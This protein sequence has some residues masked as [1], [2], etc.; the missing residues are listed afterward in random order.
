ML[1]SLQAIEAYREGRLQPS[2]GPA[3]LNLI[4]SAEMPI[5]N[6]ERVESLQELDQRN[7]VLDYVERSL[8]LLDSL[9]LSYWIK[10]LAEETLIWSETAKGGT[11]RQRRRWQEEGLNCFAHNIGSAQLYWQHTAEETFEVAGRPQASALRAAGVPDAETLVIVHRLIETHG[12][13][14]QQIRGE[15]PPEVNRPLAVIME[16]GLLTADELERLLFA[17]NHCIIGAVSPVLWQDVRSEIMELIAAVTSG[18]PAEPLPMK[19]RLRRMRSGPIL[20]GEDFAAEWSRLEQEGLPAE[21]LEELQPATFWYAES[22]LQTFSLEQFL[23]VLALAARSSS[24]GNSS[25]GNG[26]G[27]GHLSFEAVMNSIYYDYKGTK[28]I[29]VYKKRIIEKYLSGL[30]WRDIAEGKLA[31]GNPHLVHKL[32]RQGH[33]PDTVF[34]DFEFS[35][36]A[37]KLIEFCMEAEK[38]VL[39]ERAVLMLFDLFELR[40]DAFDRF[41]NEDSYLSQMND[42]ADYK[43]VILDYITGS[44][45]LDIGPGG[46]VL[47]DLIEERMPGVTPVGIDISSNVIEAL[48]QR[49]AREGRHWEVLQGDALNLKEYVDAGRVDTVIFS[50]I[51]HELYSYVPMDGRKFNHRTVAAA[52]TSAFEVLAEGGV[53]IIRDGIMTEPETQQRRIRF[54]EENGLEWLKRYAEDFAG[55]EIQYQVLSEQEVQMPVNDAMEFLYTYTWGAEAYVHEVQE[56]FGYF[57]PSQYEAF[58]RE[59]LSGRAQLEVFRHYLQEG[60]TEALRGRVNV[61]DEDGNGVPLPDSTCFIVIRKGQ[62]AD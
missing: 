42:T 61:M 24:G 8:R 17:L 45:V 30:S 44:T 22:A 23:K 51:L 5:V 25:N 58:I 43:S 47:L 14:G 16:E 36:A 28:K 53:I 40:R 9:Q 11:P 21:R 19:E 7:P 56:Q 32:R 27:L 20:R 6:L 3:W 39:Y 1:K 2:A 38:S 15:V 59:H 50:S 31:P 33:L 46:G 55:R 49:K 37:E 62:A 29:N 26:N 34:F 54:L 60:Y 57:T 4:V 41:H 18:E 13:L 12:L 10:E 35:P 48:Q 52:L